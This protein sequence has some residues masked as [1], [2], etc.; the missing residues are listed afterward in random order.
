MRTRTVANKCQDMEFEPREF[1]TR[2]HSLNHSIYSEDVM[3]V[4]MK[5]IYS[6]KHSVHFT[7]LSLI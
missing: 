2:I 4:N 6:N 3:T 7:P 5:S 1:D